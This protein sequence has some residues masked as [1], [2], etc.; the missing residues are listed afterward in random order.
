MTNETG[1]VI[2]QKVCHKGAMHGHLGRGGGRVVLSD[3]ISITFRS[4]N[5]TYTEISIL[6]HGIGKTVS[7]QSYVAKPKQT[8][9]TKRTVKKKVKSKLE[10]QS[11]IEQTNLFE[12]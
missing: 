4:L 5:E 2:A 3:G 10:V 12:I 11:K 7:N 8:T 6:H 9:L 1:I